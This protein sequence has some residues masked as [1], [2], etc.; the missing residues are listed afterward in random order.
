MEFEYVGGLRGSMM[1]NQTEIILPLYP[2]YNYSNLM[3][4]CKSFSLLKK[5]DIKHQWLMST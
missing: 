3:S 5:L 4:A 1:T 2:L